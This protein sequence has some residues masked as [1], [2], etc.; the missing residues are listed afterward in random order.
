MFRLLLTRN[1]SFIRWSSPGVELQ[2]RSTEPLVTLVLFLFVELN[3]HKQ[4]DKS[5]NAFT[6][7]ICEGVFAL[8]VLLSHTEPLTKM[9]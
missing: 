7:Y 3:D 5:G 6:S 4:V 2:E 1:W 8:V 9:C